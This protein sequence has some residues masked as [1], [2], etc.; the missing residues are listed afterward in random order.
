MKWKVWF[1]LLRSFH[2]FPLSGPLGLACAVLDWV[3]SFFD[4]RTE[5]Q[6]RKSREPARPNYSSHSGRHSLRIE[7]CFL[8]VGI[9]RSLLD[10]NRLCSFRLAFHLCHL[11]YI[12][13]P[14]VILKTSGSRLEQLTRSTVFLNVSFIHSV[15]LLLRL[16]PNPMIQTN[17]TNESI[18]NGRPN[19]FLKHQ[20]KPRLFHC[21]LS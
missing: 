18:A 20:S 1:W 13:V 9:P 21:V 5:R 7:E 15:S 11:L 4:R 19:Q 14:T 6:R 12:F 3:A 16:R 8:S 17:K 10:F 2:F